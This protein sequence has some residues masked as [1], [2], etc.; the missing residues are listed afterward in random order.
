MGDTWIADLRHYLEDGAIGSDMPRPALHIALYLGSIVAW[1][2]SRES[3]GVVQQTNVPCRRS[4]GRRRCVTEI[5]ANFEDHRA[6]IRWRCP[7]C[8]DN[9]YI[10]GWQGTP[11]DRSKA[12]KGDGAHL[13]KVIEGWCVRGEG[14][15][16]IGVGDQIAVR[17]TTRDRKLLE[18]VDLD[19]EYLE[20]LRPIPGST[21]QV[22][23]YTLDDLE[24]IL[25][26]V[27]AEANHAESPRRRQQLDDFYDRLNRTQR[28]YDDGNWNDSDT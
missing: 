15:K 17:F 8:G 11:W 7:K 3:A 14:R 16:G 24:D 4:P 9:G 20:R 27:A 21:D 25:G 19:P 23:E 22:G 28:S 2:T 12:A 18:D 26:Y 13:L 6:T 10:H 1:M 5:E